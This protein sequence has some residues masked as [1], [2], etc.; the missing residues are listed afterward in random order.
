MSLQK[1]KDKPSSV[2]LSL[3]SLLPT[4]LP[5]EWSAAHSPPLLSPN[6]V[7]PPFPFVPNVGRR[8]TRPCS[9]PLS[10]HAA[11]ALLGAGAKGDT[12]DQM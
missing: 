2:A 11:L 8:L 5:I 4:P 1:K 3:S 7:R 9:S 12:L 10:I 6:H